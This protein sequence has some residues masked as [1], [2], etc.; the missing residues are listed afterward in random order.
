MASKHWDHDTCK[1]C[2]KPIDEACKFSYVDQHHVIL[3]IIHTLLYDIIRLPQKCKND[4]EL[5]ICFFSCTECVGIDICASCYNTEEED[6]WSIKGKHTHKFSH[7]M[8]RL[9]MTDNGMLIKRVWRG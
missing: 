4:N 7:A 5:L 1:A 3:P 2:K 6:G 9:D 8:I